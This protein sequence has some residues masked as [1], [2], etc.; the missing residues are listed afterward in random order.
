M[1]EATTGESEQNRK[2]FGASVVSLVIHVL[3]GA[4]VFWFAAQEVVED[5][6][7]DVE[8]TFF[9]Q[10][11]PPP[12]PPPPPAG[13][14]K[15]TTQ[16]KPKVEKKPEPEP[17]PVQPDELVQP[18]EPE[19]PPEEEEDEPDESEDEE[20]VDGGEEGG[21]E[22]GEIG[23]EVGGQVGGEVGGK[24][25]GEIGGDINSL[26]VGES[27]GLCARKPNILYPD[28]A[29]QLG[30]EGNVRVRIL[31]DTDGKTV[32]RKDEACK[33]FHSADKKE[34]RVRWHPNLC[35]EAVS[36][37][38]I[39]YYDTLVA[40]GTAKWRPWVSGNVNARYYA[41]VETN[42]KLQ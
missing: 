14:K 38:E 35:I 22:G 13:G 41:N 33:G 32:K 19:T 42:Y 23:G 6:P 30:V 27:E 8:I 18:D 3:L 36:G 21:E 16:K 10:K 4:V 12:P 39:L 28:Q 31:V 15:K 34:R 11:P 17:E 24:V 37:P 26:G 1:F 7:Q 40:W 29:K 2:S 25:G 9:S 20:F 5:T